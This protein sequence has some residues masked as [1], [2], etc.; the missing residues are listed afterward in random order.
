MLKALFILKIFQFFV[1]TSWS[2]RNN[3]LI[4]NI[5]LIL[6]FMTSQPGKQT[7]QYK[8]CTKSHEVKTTR[9]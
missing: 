9:E 2:Y 6:N 3:G 8:Y 7:I 5:G 1:L 4:C